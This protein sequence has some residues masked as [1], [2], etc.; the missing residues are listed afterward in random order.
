MTSQKD[1][2]QYLL[3]IEALNDEMAIIIKTIESIIPTVD[4]ER[5]ALLR[6]A[7]KTLSTQ[8]C[9]AVRRETSC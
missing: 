7:V 9:K 8:T 1:K 4:I 6:G 5:A 3:E 2:D